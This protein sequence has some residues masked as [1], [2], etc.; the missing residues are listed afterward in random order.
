MQCGSRGE[1]VG[2]RRGVL[3]DG[4]LAVH[5]DPSCSMA[6]CSEPLTFHRR[7]G[8]ACSTL[9]LASPHFASASPDRPLASHD[10]PTLPLL[11]VLDFRATTTTRAPVPATI[12]A[13]SLALPFPLDPPVLL[14]VRL[15]LLCRLGRIAHA[16]CHAVAR[17]Q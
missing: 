3:L 8:I 9:T 13:V 16:L 7:F 11:V 6:S 10:S 15:P 2:T 5:K 4:H 14:L 12:P 1:W 17:W